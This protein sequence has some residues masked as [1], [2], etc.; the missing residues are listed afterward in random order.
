MVP[1]STWLPVGKGLVLAIKSLGRDFTGIVTEPY[2]P[3]GLTSTPQAL[4]P[5]SP[6]V[7]KQDSNDHEQS[8][9]VDAC[10]VRA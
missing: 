4:I 2:I 6:A 1:A 9:P 3:T 10:G 5:A 7:W 8:K